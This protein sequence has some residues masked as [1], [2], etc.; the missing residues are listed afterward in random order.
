ALVVEAEA[1]LDAFGKHTGAKCPWGLVGSPHEDLAT[2]EELNA[3]WPADVEV[4]ADDLL[5]ELAS[6]NGPVEDV[7]GADLH[8]HDAE[9]VSIAYSS[10]V[11]GERMR[12]DAQPL[13][14]ECVDVLG[15]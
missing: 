7:G 11:G 12:E 9:L 10:V 1:G 4:V 15:T 8:L 14:E 5:E 2:E 6:M 13:A 3:V